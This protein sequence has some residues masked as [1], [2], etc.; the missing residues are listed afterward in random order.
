MFLHYRAAQVDARERERE[1]VGGACLVIQSNTVMCTR[2]GREG[3]R[4]ALEVDG[5]SFVND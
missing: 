3:E 1:R 5:E 4:Y 2:R